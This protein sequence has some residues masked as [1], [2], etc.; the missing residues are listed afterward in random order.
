MRK[1]NNRVVVRLTEEQFSK[2]LDFCEKGNLSKEYFWLCL[3][4]GEEFQERR[5]KDFGKLIYLLRNIGGGLNSPK[6]YFNITGASFAPVLENALRL[7]DETED[8]LSYVFY[9]HMRKYYKNGI[10]WSVKND[11]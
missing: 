10:K 9:P 3:V 11:V 1:R 7:L 8:I 5:P 2:M 4:K 6:D